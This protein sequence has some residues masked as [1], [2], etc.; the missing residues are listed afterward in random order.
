MTYALKAADELAKEGIEAEVIDLRTLRPL[1]TDTIVA[2]V[3]KTGRAVTVE[4]GW[5]QNGVGAEVAARIVQHAFDYLD[6]PV[7][8]VSGKDVPMPY[9]ANLEKLALPSAAEVVEAAKNVCYR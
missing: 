4:E 3:K 1:D 5:Q 8:R 7:L 2:S 9:A 6:A